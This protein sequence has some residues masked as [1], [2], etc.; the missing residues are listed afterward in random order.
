MIESGSRTSAVTEPSLSESGDSAPVGQSPD[1]TTVFPPTAGLPRSTLQ[2]RQARNIGSHLYRDAVRVTV[3]MVS[4]LALYFSLHTMMTGVRQGWLGATVAQ[5]AL[6]AFPWGFLAG[7]RFPVTLLAS[8]VVVGAYRPGAARRDG[9][10]LVK[11]AGLA[12]LLILYLDLWTGSVFATLGRWAVVTMVF[13][14]GLMITRALVDALVWRFRPRVAVSR[15]LVVAHTDADWRDLALMLARVRDF[16]V[17]GNVMLRGESGGRGI[18]SRLRDLG[19]AIQECHAETVLLWGHLTAEEFSFAVD[20]ALAS[21][22]RLL[23]GARTSVG[24]VE[25]RSVWVGGRQL[26]ELTPPTLRGWQV[27]VKRAMDVVGA[28]MGLLLSVPFFLLVAIAILLEDGFPVFFRQRRVGRAGRPFHILKFR[29]MVKD[30]EGRLEE[31]RRQSIYEDV[32]LF[33][34]VD[35]PR[36]TRVG[37]VLRRTSLDELPQ[38]INVLL[39]HMSLVGPRPPLPSE[40]E[41]YDDRHYSRFDVKPGITG[42]W[43]AGGRNSV[44]DFEAVV[45]MECEYVRKWSVV[46]DLRI[47][48]RTI[49]VVLRG[50]GAH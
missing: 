29:S 8:L 10:R 24:D 26:V 20:V 11:A 23:A 44:T 2:Q 19:L 39:G 46:E 13:A 22:C 38:L 33:K 45:R 6:S 27:A 12:T 32:R 3:L 47:L 35:D 50:D 42:P 49:P 5:W 37:R 48:F 36:I 28:S 4:D 30:A 16:V 43:Q 17:V 25:P 15:A 7:P 41:S 1:L 14:L 9:A 31:L 34:V 40:V 18:H 21:G